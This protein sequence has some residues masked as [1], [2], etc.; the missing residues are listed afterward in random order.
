MS[1][2]VIV[3]HIYHMKC[4]KSRL[5]DMKFGA[6]C[7]WIRSTKRTMKMSSDQSHTCCLGLL[8]LYK[9]H[10]LNYIFTRLAIVNI[11]KFDLLVLMLSLKELSQILTGKYLWTFVSKGTSPNWF[12]EHYLSFSLSVI[13]DSTLFFYWF[14]QFNI[15]WIH[16]SES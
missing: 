14:S 6:V 10:E 16:P 3:E 1:L 13:F 8:D 9:E 12:C 7:W 11:F 15:Q 2:R 4:S 5:A